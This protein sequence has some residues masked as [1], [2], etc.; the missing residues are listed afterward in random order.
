[1]AAQGYV[2]PIAAGKTPAW[3]AFNEQ[4]NGPRRKDFEQE[5]RKAGMTHLTAWLQQTPMGDLAMLYFEGKEPAKVMATF[6]ASTGSF[7][8]WFKQQIKEI[9]GLDLG[10]LPALPTPATGLDLK[11]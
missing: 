2:A 1:M 8:T 10:Q 7:A 9:Y 4:L 11:F 5:C 6:A 3:K